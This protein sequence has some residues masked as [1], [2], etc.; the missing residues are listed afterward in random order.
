MPGW[1]RPRLV[2]SPSDSLK[3]L[4]L[5][6]SFRRAALL[7]TGYIRIALVLRLPSIRFLRSTVCKPFA[8]GVR[9][10]RNC[11]GH[12]DS[13]KDI[14]DATAP[15]EP[16]SWDC[17]QRVTRTPAE[18]SEQKNALRMEKQTRAE[19][20]GLPSSDACISLSIEAVHRQAAFMKCYWRIGRRFRKTFALRVA[21]PGRLI[22]AR[23][24]LGE[25]AFHATP[26]NTENS[27]RERVRL[28]F[29]SPPAAA[30][31]TTHYAMFVNANRSLCGQR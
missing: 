6:T 21:R 11:L 16:L 19:C 13:S 9:A 15:A 14:A 31:N 30:R 25:C 28:S 10:I 3:R 29:H 24:R 8:G 23:E 12:N 27:F 17:Y 2:S 26:F 7:P 20:R 18:N 4:V 5:L 1:A 22:K